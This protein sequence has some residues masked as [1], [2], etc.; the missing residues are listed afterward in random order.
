MDINNLVNMANRIGDFFESMPDK[1][2]AKSGIANHLS[3]FWEPR[4][5]T[6]LISKINDAS[7]ADLHQLVRQAINENLE[8]LAVK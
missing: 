6:A 2:E 7:T 1:I 4:M 3:K 8:L 5:R